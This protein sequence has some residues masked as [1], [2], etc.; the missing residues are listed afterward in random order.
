MTQH[1][2]LAARL[3]AEAARTGTRSRTAFFERDKYADSRADLEAIVRRV[4][5]GDPLT[6]DQLHT[7]GNGL[8][9]CLEGNSFEVGFGL[10]YGHR[11]PE[12]KPYA[13][14]VD[15]VWRHEG[16]KLTKKAAAAATAELFGLIGKSANPTAIR[17]ARRKFAAAIEYAVSYQLD[18]YPEMTRRDALA[19]VRYNALHE[20]ARELAK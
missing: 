18:H 15:A 19:A 3:L 5:A 4:T 16:E 12:A 14:A 10:T 2:R 1:A 17:E 20:A 9:R 7:I 6:P 13:M 11:P 8:R